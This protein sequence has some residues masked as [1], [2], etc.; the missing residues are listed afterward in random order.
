MSEALA[1]RGFLYQAIDFSTIPR[2]KYQT[3]DKGVAGFGPAF[4]A[5]RLCSLGVFLGDT[6][7]LFSGIIKRFMVL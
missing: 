6:S 2:V 1:N 5:L 4:P 3:T 7:A